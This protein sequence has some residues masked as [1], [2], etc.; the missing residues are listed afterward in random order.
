MSGNGGNKKLTEPYMYPDI[1]NKDTELYKEQLKLWEPK[2]A[3]GLSIGPSSIL[4]SPFGPDLMLQFTDA[5]PFTYPAD[6]LAQCHPINLP[7]PLPS[8]WVGAVPGVSMGVCVLAL[9]KSRSKITLTSNNPMEQII[10]EP[11]FYDDKSDAD[12]VVDCLTKLRG[13]TGFDI[14]GPSG[15]F[16]PSLKIADPKYWKSKF[17]EYRGIEVYPGAN[18]ILGWED[19]LMDFTLKCS[20]SAYHVFGSSPMGLLSATSVVDTELRVHGVKNLR[21][22]DASVIPPP[23]ITSGPMATTYMIGERAAHFIGLASEHDEL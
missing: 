5:V 3:G 9:P 1:L 20:N 23:Y 16:G 7:F 21:I 19:D 12:K 15:I 11:N 18:G 22:A 10:F 14:D 17:R 4:G 8:R 6:F 2:G 13:R